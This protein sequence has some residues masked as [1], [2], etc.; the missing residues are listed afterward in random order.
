[1]SSGEGT[2]DDACKTIMKDIGGISQAKMSD[3]CRRLNIRS[4]LIAS[5]KG[6][7]F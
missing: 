6:A 1:M 4:G 3:I 5:A 2:T 7:V